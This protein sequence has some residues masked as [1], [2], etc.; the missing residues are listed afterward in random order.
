MTKT[1]KKKKRK[2][3]PKIHG[4]TPFLAI[5]WG[6]G[7]F[8][9]LLAG[10]LI[11]GYMLLG[12]P[13]ISSLRHY[14]PPMVTQVLDSEMHPLAYW[15]KEKRWPVPFSRI[16]AR[17]VH[18]FLAAEDARFYEHPGIDFIGVMRAI[19]KNV[20]AGEIVQGA[21]TIT[22]QV[23][24]SL[25]LTRKRSWIR[26]LKEAILAWQIDAALTKNEILTIYLNQIYL[27]QGAYGVEAAAR[28]YF[29]KHVNQLSLAEC[30]ILAGLPK[31]PSS[32]NPVKNMKAAK[33]R[34][35]YVLRRMT[36]EGYITREEAEKAR[37]EPIILRREKLSPPPGTEYFLAEVKRNLEARYGRKRLLTDGL[38]IITTLNSRWQKHAVDSMKKGINR[39]CRIHRGD[40][41]LA[42]HI[43][44]ALVA[45][46]GSTGAI[47]AMVGGRDFK[48]SQFNLAT[49]AHIQT[50]SA[51]KPI[52]YAAALKERIVQPNSVLVDE[53]ITLQGPNPDTPWKPENFDKTYMGP[54]TVRTALTDSRNIVSVKIARMTGLKSI[55]NLAFQMGIKAHLANNL[56]IALG[57]SGIPPI[58]MVQAYSTFLNLGQTVSPQYIQE[59]RDRHG[60]ILET[61][62]PVRHRV[63]DPVTSFQMLYLL[64]GVVQNGTG[65]CAKKLGI[66]AAGKTGTTDE[67]R[68]A[69]FIGFSPKVVT[70]VWVGRDDHKS[71][72]KLETGG[73]VAC[74]IWRDFMKVTVKPGQPQNFPVPQ[75]IAFVPVDRRSGEIITP[76]SKNEGRIVWEALREDELPALSPYSGWFRIPSWLK[77]LDDLLFNRKRSTPFEEYR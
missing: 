8:V 10:A 72:G 61:L 65:R 28:T 17:L 21:S 75:G 9:S 60:N 37:K 41:E 64:E 31:A 16:P 27:G 3:P 26:K 63:L 36:E 77:H 25:L 43:Q 46:E 7:F 29:A 48:K 42:R 35:E 71:L 57:S 76:K 40:R 56:S 50:G 58:Q 32:Y 15:Y 34:Q 55:R 4:A 59:V 67:Y 51:I 33:R 54:I 47:R 18:A 11:V 14:S 70:A 22:Q 12:L 39:L 24:R 74:P 66:P 23:T 30:A 45:M 62:E 20:E 52:V 13:D 73:K 6:S 38:T 49:Q 53:P 69:W 2:S 19:L 44:G 1:G 68:D 5:I